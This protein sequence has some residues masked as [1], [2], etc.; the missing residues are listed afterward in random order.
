MAFSVDQMVQKYPSSGQKPAS[1]RE[2]ATQPCMPNKECL[3]IE[4]HCVDPVLIFT[5]GVG[6][7]RHELID[8]LLSSLTSRGEA[9]TSFTSSIHAAEQFVND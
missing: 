9:F 2:V 8:L 6:L 7:D 3:G 4:I 5:A 1:L